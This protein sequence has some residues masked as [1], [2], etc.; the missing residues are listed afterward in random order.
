MRRRQ[1]RKRA[2]KCGCVLIRLAVSNTLAKCP[3]NAAIASATNHVRRFSSSAIP[4]VPPAK[5]AA[6]T[7][8]VSNQFMQAHRDAAY[9]GKGN[10]FLVRLV[11]H[12]DVFVAVRDTHCGPFVLDVND[13][14]VVLQ[15]AFYCTKSGSLYI[16]GTTCKGNCRTNVILHNVKLHS[17]RILTF[18]SDPG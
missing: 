7:I 11:C 8:Y 12:E 9:F 1:R 18:C 15:R 16:Y 4:L 14:F 17:I 13:E 3:S 6:R 2:A 5:A 10:K